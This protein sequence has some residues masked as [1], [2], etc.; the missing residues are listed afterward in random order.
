MTRI[1]ECRLFFFAMMLTLLVPETDAWHPLGQHAEPE[2][3]ITEIEG[4]LIAYRGI[5]C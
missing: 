5:L 2:G 3:T 4:R 1:S